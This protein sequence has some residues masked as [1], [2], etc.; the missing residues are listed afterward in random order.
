MPQQGVPYRDRRTWLI[1]VRVIRAWKLKI[2]AIVA[3]GCAV[4]DDV[5]EAALAHAKSHVPWPDGLDVNRGFL[6]IHVG[7]EAVWLLVDLWVADI[8]RHFLYHAPLQSVTDFRPGP[9]D[10]TTACVW[11]LSVIQHERNAWVTHVLSTPESP[12]LLA[13]END[14]LNLDVA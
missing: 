14:C 11:E 7:E 1:G 13:W 5:V 12:D 6:T 2:Y 4:E 10:G 3:D 9:A 8:M